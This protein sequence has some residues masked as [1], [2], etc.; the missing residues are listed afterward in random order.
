MLTTALKLLVLF[1]LIVEDSTDP[2]VQFYSAGMKAGGRLDV[3]VGGWSA[4]IRRFT[5]FVKGGWQVKRH[6]VKY[7]FA[8]GYCIGGVD[9]KKTFETNCSSIVMVGDVELTENS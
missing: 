3:K 4:H 7:A 1:L 5:I 2:F 6:E 9:D 8:Y